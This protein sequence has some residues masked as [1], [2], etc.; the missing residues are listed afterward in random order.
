MGDDDDPK[1]MSECFAESFAA[2]YSRVS[3]NNPAPHQHFDD[4]IDDMVITPDHVR[5]ILQGLDANSAMGPDGIHPQLLK[6]CASEL[7]YPLCVIFRRSLSEG[8]VPDLWK[9]STVI[10]IFKKGSRNDPLN[11]RPVSLTS[12]CCKTME[13][14][15]TQHLTEFLEDRSLLN[16]NQFRFRA[17]RSTMDQLLLV[18]SEVSKR[19]DEGS[20][21]DVI[22]FDYSKA[23]DVVCHDILLAKL[24]L[25]GVR[26]E[27][28][29]WISSFLSE[30]VMRVSALGLLSQ[31]RDVLSGVPQ[32]S[33]LGPLLFLVYINH[34]G[35]NLTCDYK[36]FADDLKIY[37]CVHRRSGPSQLPSDADIQS[38]IDLLFNT[39]MSWGLMMNPKK[40]AVLSFSRAYSDLIPAEYFLNGLVIPSVESHLDL[41]VTVDTDLKFHSHIRSVVRK[42]GGLAQNFLKSTVCREPEFMLFLLTVHIRPIIE[43]CSCVWATGYQGDLRLLES[44]QRRWTKQ[45]SSVKGLGYADRLHALNLYSVK[46]RL[47]RA[48]LIQY[49]KIFNGL[50]RIA[51]EDLFV[52][53]PRHATRGHCYKIFMQATNTDV[54]K[55]FF[56]VRSVPAWN[57]LPE[58]VVT[59]PNLS[60]FKKLLE[61]SLGSV[62]LEY[63]E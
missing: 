48:D 49:W 60:S 6:S 11:Y 18:Y 21:V 43:Y 36:I 30:R 19:V 39:F 29:D 8:V 1:A 20:A 14:L 50:S 47:M 35:A 23:F 3:P 41:G 12:V 53:S 46:G 17:G 9:E 7:A 61:K 25:I 26:G 24:R 10:P 59:A 27:I 40:C 31:P 32:G 55:R 5:T 63:V 15:I 38:D 2:V 58:H 51:A 54:R 56:N 33:V 62:L 13:R 44:V 52:L 22:L 42:A 45:I 16:P 4:Q 57:S 37:A 34:V 28:L